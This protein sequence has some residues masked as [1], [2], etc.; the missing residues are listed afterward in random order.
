MKFG[1]LLAQSLIHGWEPH[2][3][4]YW[5]LKQ[6][7]KAH[8]T[9]VLTQEPPI[10]GKEGSPQSQMEDERRAAPSF[11]HAEFVELFK[12]EERRVAQFV[13][14][15]LAEI[16]NELDFAAKRPGYSAAA[17]ALL[18]THVIKFDRFVNDTLVSQ[19]KI[20]KKYRKYTNQNTA[21]FDEKKCMMANGPNA[22]HSLI[23]ALS[24]LSERQW[25]QK[26]DWEPPETF[27]RKT[28]KYWVR[29]QHAVATKLFIIQHLPILEI[30]KTP[31]PPRT[32]AGESHSQIHN[33][34]SSVYMDNS[35]AD[36]YHRR[37]ALEEGA[38]L[39][40]VRWYGGTEGLDGFP[41]PSSTGTVFYMELKTH[42]DAETTGMKS[43]KE[44]FPITS[45]MIPGFMSGSL[46][47]EQVIDAMAAQG[48]IKLSK[49]LEQKELASYM[50]NL[51][52]SMKLKP[53]IRTVYHRT[54]FQRSD[55]NEVRISFDLPLILHPEPENWNGKDWMSL[56]TP[57]HDKDALTFGY[58]V[59][60]VKTSEE[61][62]QWVQEL[63]ATGWLIRVEKFSKF[64]HATAV[65]HKESVKVMP[66]WI[67]SELARSIANEAS[68]TA[69]QLLQK[70][71]P[72]SPLLFDSR[73]VPLSMTLRDEGPPS[74]P[75][76]PHGADAFGSLNDDRLDTPLLGKRQQGAKSPT[77]TN[78]STGKN[79]ASAVEKASLYADAS[80]SKSAAVVDVKAAAPPRTNLTRMRI[81][82]KV[83]FAN[84]RTF[85]KWMFAVVIL[86]SVSMT[87][88][89]I[90]NAT[91]KFG[92]SLLA[93]AVLLIVYALVLYRWRLNRILKRDTTRFDDRIGPYLLGGCLMAAAV[94]VFVYA[95][96]LGTHDVF[97]CVRG[98]PTCPPFQILP[99]ASLDRIALIGAEMQDLGQALI[100]ASACSAG[101]KG[102]PVVVWDVNNT[103]IY[104]ASQERS[105]VYM[106]HER[107]LAK[108]TLMAM[109]GTGFHDMLVS[110]YSTT[111]LGAISNR[112]HGLCG[113]ISPFTV[114]VQ[115]G[116]VECPRSALAFNDLFGIPLFENNETFT[117]DLELRS[118]YTFRNIPVADAKASLVILPEFA[119]IY[120]RAAQINTMNVKV[121][122][123][124]S[125]LPFNFSAV[126][127]GQSLLE[128][129]YRSDTTE[130]HIDVRWK[131]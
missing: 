13:N 128:A 125:E 63:L 68:D 21:W 56:F 49:V 80:S 126:R 26:A 107:D 19:Q 72:M 89:S 20:L 25:E 23:V 115:T 39:L 106:K 75:Q 12:K 67:S 7:I 55:S 120:D 27:V 17:A 5:M 105:Q 71:V 117:F 76:S 103:F 122:V 29:P 127:Q 9:P 78:R 109:N 118:R 111:I 11:D 65:F 58:G 98:P 96:T 64:Q 46:N 50:Q 81:E 87:L 3:F 38:N 86:I 119:N 43:T 18:A 8:T 102:D 66:Y 59:L 30:N 123:D 35:A 40:R 34:L 16:A 131:E 32:L 114:V 70:A 41:R 37:I 44:R 2:Y 121:E 108:L 33:Y 130:R 113:S 110:N 77:T 91:I 104:L 51:I 124:M 69:Q 57:M 101:G 62:P 4:D 116:I 85:L 79:F 74:V 82:P 95:W 36:S 22:V 97:I 129:L 88:L 83:F 99:N 45:N 61:P 48:Q 53:W 93:I 73:E 28:V 47:P 1:D 10:G 24:Q 14:G 15:K 90:S 112:L 6:Y 60:E 54:A 84:E 31:A 94:V 42:H 52:M 92:I 100:R